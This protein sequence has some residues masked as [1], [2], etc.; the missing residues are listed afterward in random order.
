LICTPSDR[1]RCSSRS[2]SEDHPPIGNRAAGGTAKARRSRS[3]T[4]AAE[5]EPGSWKKV[6]TPAAAASGRLRP[7][8]SAPW[9]T[10]ETRCRRGPSGLGALRSNAPCKRAACAGLL[11]CTG[12]RGLS[13]RFR[14]PAQEI[15]FGEPG[16][17]RSVVVERVRPQFAAQGPDRERARPPSSSWASYRATFAPL[18]LA[19]MAATM[20]A[21]PPPTTLIFA[22]PKRGATSCSRFQICFG[23]FCRSG[24]L[25][26]M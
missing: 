2:T 18:S 8:R 23:T 13:P 16:P 26:V 19:V 24:R 3:A 7:P 11:P 6:A 15:A 14:P 1:I 22:M 9:P 20:P 25:S 17:E 12:S 21:N 5:S 10:R 4:N